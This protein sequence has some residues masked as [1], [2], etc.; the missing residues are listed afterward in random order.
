M[1][2]EPC[3]CQGFSLS[4]CFLYVKMSFQ[5]KKYEKKIIDNKNIDH[6]EKFAVVLMD[7]RAK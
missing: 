4:K 1:L 3:Y 5:K 7:A 6:S 2:M